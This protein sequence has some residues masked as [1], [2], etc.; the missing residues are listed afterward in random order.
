MSRDE[1]LR[2]LE[3]A[4]KLGDLNALRS[5]ADERR[6]RGLELLPAD[7]HPL[8]WGEGLGVLATTRLGALKWWEHVLPIDPHR[9]MFSAL[10]QIEWAEAHITQFARARHLWL[11]RVGP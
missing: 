10:E 7:A 9:R 4:A 11:D 1:R 2:D 8:G 5:W 3:R 6:R